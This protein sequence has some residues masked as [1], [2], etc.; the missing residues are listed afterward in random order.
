MSVVRRC[1]AVVALA[2]AGGVFW[3]GAAAFGAEATNG[4]TPPPPWTQPA[5]SEAADADDEGGD[6][7]SEADDGDGE[8][9]EASQDAS[10]EI[11][12]PS[13]NISEDIDVPFPVDI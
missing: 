6:E 10:A 3:P 13:E 12:V 9:D 8:S 5:E 1:R 11:F 7:D 2:A 4:P